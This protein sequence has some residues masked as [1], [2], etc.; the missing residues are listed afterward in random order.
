[1][2]LF[3]ETQLTT[4]YNQEYRKSRE[5]SKSFS[6]QTFINE[7]NKVVG[8]NSQYDI[9]LSHSS[10]D[11]KLIVG[12][13]G[14]LSDMG[15]KVYVDWSDPRLNNN[16]VT[17]ETAQILR[18]RMKQCKTLIYAFSE[19]AA[20][21]KWMPWELGYFDGLK[22]S[23]VAVLPI[24]KV[25]RCSYSGSEYVGLYYHI[26]FDQIALTNKDAIWVHDGD[27]YVN[28]SSWLQGTLPYIHK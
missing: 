24:T 3:T 14:I 12:L 19:N 10:L 5:L 6:S 8:S 18:D 11:E 16:H 13:T 15:Y 27:K 28:F 21:S 26:Q 4:R 25:N 23:K 22:Q 7:S 17:P 2:A 20:S 9:F 1:M